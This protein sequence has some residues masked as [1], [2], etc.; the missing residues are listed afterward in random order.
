MAK[1]G[2][3]ILCALECSECG[4]RNYTTERNKLNTPKL[5]LMKY[6][7][8]CKKHTLHKCKDKLK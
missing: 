3:R 6:C 8:H 2:A 7:K 1:K 5:E 4:A